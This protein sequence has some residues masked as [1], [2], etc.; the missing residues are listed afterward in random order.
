MLIVRSGCTCSIEGVN[1]VFANQLSIS[2]ASGDL[3]HTRL[4]ARSHFIGPHGPHMFYLLTIINKHT[5]CCHCELH[6]YVWEQF[7][8]RNCKILLLS[9]IPNSSHADTL[10]WST[11]ILPI[12]PLI[13]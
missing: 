9:L 2:W 8:G 13:I 6:F 12:G 10:G 3:D 11:T 4:A 7:K 5:K 1:V